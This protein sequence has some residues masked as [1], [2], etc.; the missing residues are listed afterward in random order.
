M[1]FIEASMIQHLR[2]EP[3]VYTVRVQDVVPATQRPE[4][5]HQPKSLARLQRPPLSHPVIDCSSLSAILSLL[6]RLYRASNSH[7]VADDSSSPYA[8]FLICTSPTESMTCAVYPDARRCCPTTVIDPSSPPLV[9]VLLFKNESII[10]AVHS[11]TRR[12]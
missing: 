3:D 7:P 5:G 10:R 8:I 9:A 2:V 4:G 12:W 11:R 6:T 1:V